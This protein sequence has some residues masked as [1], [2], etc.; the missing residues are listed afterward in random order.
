MIAFALT[1]G[2]LALVLALAWW[3][4]SVAERPFATPWP[5][6]AAAWPLLTAAVG[7]AALV[8]V[9]LAWRRTP[10]G[11]PR[12]A[13]AELLVM[14]GLVLAWLWGRPVVSGPH[15]QDLAWVLAVALTA[16]ALLHT[17]PPLAR[18][19]APGL[20]AGRRWQAV[21]AGFVLLPVAV[22]LAAGTP[23]AWRSL[24][25]SLALYPL[26][27]FVQLALVLALPY[28]RLALLAGARTATV[29]CILIFALVHWPNPA[30]MGATALGM[31]F[32][33]DEFRQGRRLVALALSMG[34][35]ATAFTQL[36]PHDV[37]SHMR[38]GPGYVRSRAVP[39]L[40]AVPGDP[41]ASPVAGF[42]GAL[43]PTTVG[44]PATP[45]ELAR[46]DAAVGAARRGALAWYFFNT[47]ERAKRFGP[48]PDAPRRGDATPWTDLDPAWRAR[49]APFAEPV[50]HEA[51]GGTW[52]GF[53][54]CLYRDVLGREATAADLAAW[55][56]RLSD[57]ERQRLVE[58]L[59]ARHRA[60]AGTPF[61]TLTAVELELRY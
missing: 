59:L 55:P 18:P 33:T 16:F 58:V 32:W 51:C 40:A 42:L 21:N 5:L 34:L 36:L 7:A 15:L 49:I 61:D 48:L 30:L 28:P 52:E 22:A 1:V 9:G 39:V 25:L 2:N 44:R 14:P 46:W 24:G 45:P 27:A 23:V 56:Q 31:A 17:T 13:L 3:Q 8:G 41:A 29:V 47:P 12:R 50:Y 19:E 43:Y 57:R 35:A 6:P 53:L 26:Y 11:A 4:L 10:R 38:V 37:T 20:L 54:A 60:L